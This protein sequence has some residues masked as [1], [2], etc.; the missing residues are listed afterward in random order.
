MRSL[1]FLGFVLSSIFVTL[2]VLALNYTSELFEQGSGKSK[3]L[4]T[5]VTSS[6][7]ESTKETIQTQYKDLQGNV[8]I[9][10]T[11][12]LDG[13]KLVRDELKQ[14]QTNQIGLIEVK[15]GKVF[16][17]I[18]KEGKTSTKDEKLKDSLVVA[19][20]FQ[21]HVQENWDKI[22]AGDDIEF[23]YGVWHRQET[24]GFEI[25]K[26]GEDKL[27]TEEVLVL[28]M[29]PSSFIIAALVKPIIMK[30]SKSTKRLLEL[31]GRVAPMQKK[32][33]KFTDL[34]AEVIYTY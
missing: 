4:Y 26:T 1:I 18:T 3:K 5:M 2:P 9:D 15:D 30:F 14:N 6:T 11:V 23:R 24:V 32:G 21:A 8:A 20:T 27:G 12:I 29:K 28:K 10:Q 33:D 19:A 13:G 22:A 16:F 7:M 25:F 31:N 17:S 34:D